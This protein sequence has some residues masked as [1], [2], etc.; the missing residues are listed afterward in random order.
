VTPAQAA[1][2]D[3]AATHCQRVRACHWAGREIL[4]KQHGGHGT[5]KG[6]A[7]FDESNSP[8]IAV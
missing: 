6:G 3:I 5:D 7:K 8:G 1:F 2:I 4:L